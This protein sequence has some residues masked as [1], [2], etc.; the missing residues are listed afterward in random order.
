MS[1][2]QGIVHWAPPVAASEADWLFCWHLWVLRPL[3]CTRF[4]YGLIRI[5]HA[6]E[7]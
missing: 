5:R 6:F 7:D 1:L 2:A 4:G 3:I